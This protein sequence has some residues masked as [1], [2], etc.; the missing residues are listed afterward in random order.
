MN[1]S[2]SAIS[3]RLTSDASPCE[4]RSSPCLGAWTA[5]P[6]SPITRDLRSRHRHRIDDVV[7]DHVYGDA[8]TCGVRTEP[9]AMRQHVAREFLN[10]LGIHLG[11]AVQQQRP[12]LDQAS[13]ANRRA[14]RRSEI[15]DL[16]N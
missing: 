15:N 11:A 2:I 7:D 1:S 13:P 4:A 3:C 9:D 5:A 14:R 10:V 8:V 16:F 12:D 6:R